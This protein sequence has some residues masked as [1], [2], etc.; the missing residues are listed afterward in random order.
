[1]TRSRRR[2]VSLAAL[3]ILGLTALSL[4]QMSGL[5]DLT[6][7]TL[8]T[9]GGHSSQDPYELRSTVHHPIVGLS[10]GGDYELV[11]SFQLPTPGA[12]EGW[13]VK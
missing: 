10:T 13:I 1:M 3:L 2:T 5:L 8:Q 11:S 6:H 7:A 12:P 9:S 4:A